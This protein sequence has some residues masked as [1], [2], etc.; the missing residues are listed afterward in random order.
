M[1]FFNLTV[2]SSLSTTSQIVVNEDC[3]S[4][5]RVESVNDEKRLFVIFQYDLLSTDNISNDYN[6]EKEPNSQAI[7]IIFVITSMLIFFTIKM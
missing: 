2:K 4:K 1:F 7:I 3:N 5:F 6:S